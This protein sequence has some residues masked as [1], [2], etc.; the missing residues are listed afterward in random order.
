MLLCN[1]FEKRQQK[2]GMIPLNGNQ[3]TN[4]RLTAEKW[5]GGITV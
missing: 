1:I 2:R 3:H 4:S 5:G